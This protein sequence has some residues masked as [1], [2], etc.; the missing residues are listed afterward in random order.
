MSRE[1]RGITARVASAASATTSAMC[2]Q[3][4]LSDTILERL[5]QDLE[6]MAHAHGLLNQQQDALVRQGH[7]LQHRHLAAADHADVGDGVTR[8]TKEAGGD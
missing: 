6:D 1:P 8:R 7:L 5:S 4:F 3:W 2:G